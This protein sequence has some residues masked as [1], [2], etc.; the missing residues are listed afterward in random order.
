MH[1]PVT[2]F[3]F[4]VITHQIYSNYENFKK[5]DQSGPFIKH[6]QVSIDSTFS[7]CLERREKGDKQ[8]VYKSI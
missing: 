2:I 3:F 7:I 8:A 1:D 4:V 6:Q 5:R